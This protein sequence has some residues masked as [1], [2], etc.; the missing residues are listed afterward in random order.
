MLAP[1]ASRDAAKPPVGH[2]PRCSGP[3]QAPAVMLL[4]ACLLVA[5]PSF[6]GARADESTGG[7]PVPVNAVA[8]IG[9]TVE[10][11]DRSVAF[12]TGVLGFEK[13]SEEEVAGE[14]W[15][16]LSGVFGA[17]MRIA[18]L[19]L[20]SET[21][22][23]TDF[24]APRGRPYAYD[25]RA[26]DH[27]F[28][29]IAIVVSDMEAAYAR[30]RGAGVE[31]ASTGPQCLPESIPAAAG[32][33]A[34][35]FRDPDGH[36]LELLRFPPGKGEARWH[37]PDAAQGRLFL[38]IDHTAIVVADTARALDFYEGGLGL[39]VAG[40][41]VNSGTEQEHLNNVEGA[42]LR[43]TT[44]RAPRG[45][46]IELLEYLQP[47]DGR[48]PAEPPR[49]ND[50]AY[51]QTSLEVNAIPPLPFGESPGAS[52]DVKLPGGDAGGVASAVVVRDPD[53]HALRLVRRR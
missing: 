8:E 39:R 24:L 26:N 53:G 49:A 23:L 16:K 12:F 5:T 17:R 35:Y 45:P 42:R 3:G 11:L 4:A 50:V 33:C 2:R 52:T 20:G 13:V 19:R 31:H 36:F 48:R 44:L 21:I 22:E 1:S 40:A 29:H 30:L 28:Q 32:I 18:R 37:S 10:D 46:G 6:D 38:G 9:L 14:P 34:F 51:W 27:W 7:R 47:L 41:G 43:I 25:T 15:E